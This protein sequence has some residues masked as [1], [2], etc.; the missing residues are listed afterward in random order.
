MRK[1]LTVLAFTAVSSTLALA[2]DWSGTLVD[3]SCYERQNQQLKDV[4]KAVDACA[5]TSQTTTFGI[6]ASG[7]VHKLDAGGNSKATT[8]LK[9]RADRSAGKPTPGPISAKVM[10]TE[11]GDSIKVDSVEVQ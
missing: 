4:Q 6:H 9:N 5:A 8:A 7:K 3:S 11:S 2:A 1:V 10:G